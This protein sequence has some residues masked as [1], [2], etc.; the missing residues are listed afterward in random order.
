MRLASSFSEVVRSFWEERNDHGGWNGNYLCPASK[1]SPPTRIRS[2]NA[3]RDSLPPPTQGV[4]LPSSWGLGPTCWAKAEHRAMR[5]LGLTPASGR[6]Q[7]FPSPGQMQQKLAAAC[8]FARLLRSDLPGKKS[9]W[10]QP[11]LITSAGPTAAAE[12]SLQLEVP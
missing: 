8:M 5:G 1:F 12:Q 10:R 7:L 4:V 3:H 6:S 11:Y 2:S 9:G